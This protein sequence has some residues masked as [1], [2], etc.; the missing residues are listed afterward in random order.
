MSADVAMYKGAQ[1]VVKAVEGDSVTFVFLHSVDSA[2]EKLLFLVFLPA[3]C[4]A[5]NIPIIGKFAFCYIRKQIEV[6]WVHTRD[7]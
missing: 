3:T 4:C 1:T 2:T 6:T 5:Y 7:L